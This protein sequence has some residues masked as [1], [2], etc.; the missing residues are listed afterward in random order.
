MFE[1]CVT[2]RPLAYH[3]PHVPET[4]LEGFFFFFCPKLGGFGQHKM[5]SCVEVVLDLA[6]DCH[7]CLEFVDHF[8]CKGPNLLVMW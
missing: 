4:D 5:G 6:L 8:G 2:A 1:C 7:L 3:P